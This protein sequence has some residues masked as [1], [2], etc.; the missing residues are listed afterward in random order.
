MKKDD[1]NKSEKE[2]KQLQLGIPL[3]T[4]DLT[5]NYRGNNKSITIRSSVQNGNLQ[6]SN[7]NL[8]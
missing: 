7:N 1:P 3:K 2:T 5:S 6:S 4:E 8:C